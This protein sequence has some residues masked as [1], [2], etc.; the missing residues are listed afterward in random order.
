MTTYEHRDQERT[1]DDRLPDDTRERV[2]ERAP[3][4]TG[5]WFVF[6]APR[7]AEDA[8]EAER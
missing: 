5:G 4:A 7:T 3:F 2:A 1:D 6:S 8:T